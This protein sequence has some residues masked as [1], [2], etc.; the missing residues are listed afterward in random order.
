M[1]ATQVSFSS[2]FIEG[3]VNSEAIKSWE[4]KNR[5]FIGSQQ[6]QYLSSFPRS[7]NGWVRLVMAAT[8]LEINGIDIE[9]VK[10]KRE[11]TDTG[12]KYV[13]FRNDTA[14]Y[15]L[16]DIF[17]D[18]YLS[19]SR[20]NKE[21]MARDIRNLD[22]QHKV[23]KT[24]HIV[25]ISNRKTI[26]LFRDPHSCLTSASLLLNKK[27]IEENPQ[28]IN[29]TMTYLAKYY[30]K[31][32]MSYVKQKQTHPENCYF[33]DNAALYGNQAV[34]KIWTT[35]SFLGINSKIETVEKII[36]IYPLQSRYNKEFEKFITEDTRNFVD[37]LLMARYE[38][39]L[40]NISLKAS[41]SIR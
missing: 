30:D 7:G 32:L 38:Q 34:E 41:I 24:H 16:E 27:A 12:V 19:D 4:T 10:L 39:A 31:M 5:D 40:Q 6:P 1:E 20:S 13:C 21:E 17:P 26:F 33:L 35:L 18:M 3:T 28:N 23:V 25:D 36:G 14:I 22:L 11:T 15:P 9:S 29:D 8:L 2:K 37:E